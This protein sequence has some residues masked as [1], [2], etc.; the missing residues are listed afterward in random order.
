[1]NN[2]KSSKK[3]SIDTIVIMLSISIVFFGVM[4][5]AGKV[6]GNDW[7]TLLPEVSWENLIS[8]KALK[9]LFYLK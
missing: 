6:T 4:I 7:L 9:E 3:D 1:M 5:M 8:E 2:K